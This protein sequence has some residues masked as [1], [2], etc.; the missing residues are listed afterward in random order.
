MPQTTKFKL[1]KSEEKQL[2]EKLRK[3]LVTLISLVV[4]LSLLIFFFAPKLGVF[5]GFFSKHRN[6]QDETTVIKPSTPLFSNVPSATKGDTLTV[7][8]YAQPGLTVVL[9]VNGPETDKTT[10]GADGLFTFNNIELIQ[11]SNTISAKSFDQVGSES[12]SS[13]TYTIVVDREKPKITIDSPKDGEVIKNL[14]ARITVKGKIN[15]KT[16][17]KIN[18]KQ[19]ILRPDYTFEFLLGATEGNMEI[20]VEATDEAG[21]TAV[22]KITVKFVKGS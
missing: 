9:Y 18:N 2:R 6:D 17:L 3:T 14:D 16:T 12:D 10:A 13:N 1:T 19:A 11:G 4:G 21:N 7:N 22:E 20:T 8:G 15:E 5:F